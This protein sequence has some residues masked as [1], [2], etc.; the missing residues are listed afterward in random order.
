MAAPL[1][2]EPK[3]VKDTSDLWNSVFVIAWSSVLVECALAQLN[4]LTGD[5]SLIGT[6]QLTTY[7]VSVCTAVL[8]FSAGVAAVWANYP[9]DNYGRRRT[10]LRL[11]VLFIAG[12]VCTCFDE[13]ALIA[14]GRCVIGIGCGIALVAVPT[15]LM[16]AV[17]TAA[18]AALPTGERTTAVAS[19]FGR[20]TGHRIVVGA[21]FGPPVE[22]PP[23]SHTHDRSA[24]GG[25]SV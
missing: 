14:V 20:R 23:P 19:L 21:L 15:L 13:F 10:L 11:N 17:A 24:I 9:L 12:G 6:L 1:T 7:E 3:A 22:K 4:A 8:Y 2:E 18:A 16:L 5:A 25:A